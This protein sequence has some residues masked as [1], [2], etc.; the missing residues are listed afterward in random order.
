MKVHIPCLVAGLLSLA[1]SLAPFTFAQTSAQAASALP[2]LIRFGGAV[3]DLNGNPLTGVVGITFA[4]YSAQTGGAALWL[5]TQ[6]A[7]ADNNG[8]YT[9]LLGS[10]KPEG[11]PTELFTSEQARWLGVQV[12]GQAEQQRVL[13]VSAPYALKAGDAETVGGLPASAFVLA[14]PVNG[15]AASVNDAAAS[16]SASVPPPASSNVTTTGGTVNAIPLF[17]TATNI[18]NSIVTQT[19]TTTVNVAGKLNHPANGTATATAG[20]NSRPDDFVA[21]A[22]N[23]GTATAVPQ[24]FQLQAEPAGNNTATPSGTLNLL[25]GA[26]TATPAET[27]LKISNNGL[28]TFA[29]GQTFPGTGT[30]TKVTAGKGLTGGGATGA[31]TLNLDTTKVPLLAS[32]NTF[33][34]GQTINGGLR[35]GSATI[36]GLVSIPAGANNAIDSSS[37]STSAT[38]ISA[39]ASSTTGAAWGVEGDTASSASNAYG[40]VGFADSSTGSPIAIYGGHV[41]RPASACSARTATRALPARA[42]SGL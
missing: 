29:S 26:S 35:A 25:Y 12:S 7:T 30:I 20:K 1:L 18:Q 42:L 36:N 3:K 27:G 32:A 39:L 4:L 17:S 14:A 10:T 8:R 33:A 37:S 34:A 21:S 31:V 22:F 9:V 16:T 38:T 11:L 15:S 40:V 28:I 41:A 5:E 13:L 2:R 23:S 24:T 19:G 6:N